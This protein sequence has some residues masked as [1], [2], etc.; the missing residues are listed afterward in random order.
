KPKN[1]LKTLV[2]NVSAEIAKDRPENLAH[3][4]WLVAVVRGDHDVNESKL[5]RAARE[6]FHINS[7]TLEDTP[8]VRANWA[9]GFVGP[10]AAVR[11]IDT[12]LLI[13]P[14]AA[15]GGFWAA[16]A[17]E[18]DHHVKHFNWFRECG[19]K[20]ADPRKVIVS[21]IRNAVEGDPSP[22][23]DGGKL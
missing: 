6:H 15:Q 2:F 17:N 4:R 13:D 23:N 20:L 16:G 5:A 11:N 18:I 19:D 7:F 10:D 8:E 1:M 21:D 3:P 14:D 22:K 9:I 12:V